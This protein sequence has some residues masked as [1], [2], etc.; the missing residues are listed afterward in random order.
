V[1]I[2]LVQIVGYKKWEPRN[3]PLNPKPKTQKIKT[4]SR[5]LNTGQQENC[6]EGL[7]GVSNLVELWQRGVGGSERN[8][9]QK[10][11][12]DTNRKKKVTRARRGQV[13][14]TSWREKAKY[15]QEQ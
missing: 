2:I 11:E 10:K 1:F 4:S 14:A 9:M 15:S 5:K 6:E 3:Q 8:E 12:R 7:G 13:K